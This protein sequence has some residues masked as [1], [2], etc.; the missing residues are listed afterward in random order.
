MSTLHVA[1]VGAG[2]GGL[3]AAVALSRKGID[4]TIYE[5]ARQLGE[6]GAGVG[7]SHNSLRLLDRV[8]LAD[9]LR[10]TS[11]PLAETRLCDSN[12]KADLRHLP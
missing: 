3:A 2:I 11:T 12:G 8:G 10:E 9:R 7:L 6:V 1:V 4:V 5:Q